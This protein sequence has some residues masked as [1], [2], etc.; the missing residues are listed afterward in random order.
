MREKGWRFS[1]ARR[2]NRRR[3]SFE[4]G[5][6]KSSQDNRNVGRARGE[7][8]ERVAQRSWF[9]FTLVGMAAVEMNELAQLVD[10]LDRVLQRRLPAGKQRNREKDPC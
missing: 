3:W 10:V 5:G 4:V 9:R 8:G 1:D 7:S 2:A 6:R